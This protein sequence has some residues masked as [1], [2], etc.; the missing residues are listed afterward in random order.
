MPY[1][2]TNGVAYVDRD[3]ARLCDVLTCVKYK[4][5]LSSAGTLLRPNAEYGLKTPAQMAR[6]F[7]AYPRALANTLAVTERCAFRL[8]KL[9][10]QFPDF[11][12]PAGAASHH[13][14][15]RTL[16]YAGAHERY[17][18]PLTSKVE[19]QLE[20]ELGIIARMD[21][22]G[23]FLVVWDISRAAKERRVL[24]TGS[25]FGG[26]TPPSVM[27]SGSPQSIRSPATCS[28]NASSPKSA[29]RFRTSTSTSRTKIANR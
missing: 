15:L 8:E 22:S 4:A 7:A 5:T 29:K 1:V 28:S 24:G 21:L 2:A 25:R 17:G 18:R 14:Y 23:Y 27:R 3:D 13:A 26:A 12:L 16:V 11:P 6:L 19:R 9:A 10:G 20:Y